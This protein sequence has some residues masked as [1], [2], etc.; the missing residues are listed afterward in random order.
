LKELAELHVSQRR[1]NAYLI[2]L[3]LPYVPVHTKMAYKGHEGRL[4]LIPNL[5]I[6]WGKILLIPNGD[7]VGHTVLVLFERRERYLLSLPRIKPLIIQFIA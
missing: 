1:E 7:M 3:R 4:P 5:D 2:K 6:S